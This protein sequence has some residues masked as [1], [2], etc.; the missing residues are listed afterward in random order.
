MQNT[1]NNYGQEIDALA[2]THGMPAHF[3]KALV[4]LE[5][6]G[7]K[8]VK[9]RYEKHVFR[10]LQRVRDGKRSQ[11]EG[12][13]K[14][15]LE[16]ASDEALKNLARSWG[17]FQLMGYKCVQMMFKLCTHYCFHIIFH[18]ISQKRIINKSAALN[19]KY[20]LFI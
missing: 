17:P 9:P 5:C 6:S 1:R 20:S 14:E 16:D 12:I 13:N 7:W 19:I 11:I 2:E 4:V 15:M 8:P 10:R 18:F 3:L